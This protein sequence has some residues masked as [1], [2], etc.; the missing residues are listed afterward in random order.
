MRFGCVVLGAALVAAG[1][2]SSTATNVS[3]AKPCSGTKVGAVVHFRGPYTEEILAGTKAAADECGAGY[4]DAGPSGIDPPSEIKAFQDLV[5]TGVKAI[6]TVA[7]PS[8]I[9][10]RPID[11]ANK[12]GIPVS[13]YD[14]ASPASLE[15]VHVGPRN[16]DIGK[17]LADA[18][19][20]KSGA[21]AQGNV[22]LG[23]CFPGLDVLEARVT[24]FKNQVAKTAPG[25][26]V[27]GAFDTTFDPAKNFAAWQQLVQAHPDALAFV[28]V[29]EN[30]LN[31]L[32]KI[33]AKN[34]SAKYFIES[35]GINTEALQG[36]KDGVGGAA[37]GQ[38][39]FL[40]GYVAMKLLLKKVVDK[41]NFPRGWVDTGVETVTSANVDQVMAREASLSSG[42]TQSLAFYKSTL[43]KIFANPSGAITSFGDYV[44][45][46]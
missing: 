21:S 41:A 12:A 23:I 35:V 43:D 38:Q 17:A 30:D 24:G 26:K 9:W 16:V 27:L 39:P 42:P 32:E 5:Q 10:V 2:G 45:T 15:T 37:I 20:A 3:G 29:C 19:T 25:I 22:V 11:A 40:Q 1:C 18:F 46:Q 8:D 34:A 14:V 44:A 4:Q 31:A 28:G 6:S 36:I 33:K 13:T 7:Y